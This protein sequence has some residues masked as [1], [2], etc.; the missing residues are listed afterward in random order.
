MASKWKSRKFIVSLVGQIVGIV[1]IIWGS[2]TAGLV[3]TITG[4]VIII[5]TALGYLKTEGD[6]DKAKI[7]NGK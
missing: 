4:A 1:A 7:N 3:E 2:S 6:I 5:V